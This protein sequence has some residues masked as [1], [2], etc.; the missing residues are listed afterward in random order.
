MTPPPISLSELGPKS[1]RIYSASGLSAG[2]CI[3]VTTTVWF[4]GDV[5]LW[6]QPS[7]VGA[8]FGS[9]F[10][11]GL[12][13]GGVGRG[14]LKFAVAVLSCWLFS[15]LAMARITSLSHSEVLF[16]TSCLLALGWLVSLLECLSLDTNKKD[17]C[18]IQY[19]QWTMWDIALLTLWVAVFCHCSQQLESPV[20]L[21]AEVGYVLAGG[22]IASW[23]AFRWALD[24]Q[25]SIG[26]LFGLTVAGAIALWL[27]SR[28]RP[29][30]YSSLEVA[31]WMV[32]G[33]MSVISAQGFVVLAT[34]SCTR[35]SWLSPV[36]L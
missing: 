7:V 8:I 17:S 22:S 4:I 33:P 12:L 6:I 1:N 34:L 14:S 11:M 28:C 18:V 26:K 24:D 16:V 21:L 31:Q 25:W 29:I 15:H 32:T 19:R 20:Y 13:L 9:L 10:L 2:I 23:I 5:P 27:I 3:S 30:D 35:V 36:A